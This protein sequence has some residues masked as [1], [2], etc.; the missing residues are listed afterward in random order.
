MTNQNYTFEV[1]GGYLDYN[2]RVNVEYLADCVEVVCANEREQYAEMFNRRRKTRNVAI[3]WLMRFIN[4]ELGFAGYRGYTATNAQV[5]SFDR[6][7]GGGL[8]HV[9]D[10]VTEYINNH[11]REAA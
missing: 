5:M 4:M 7:H 1:L 3:D 9:L 2:N 10:N 11:R 6:Q 8:E